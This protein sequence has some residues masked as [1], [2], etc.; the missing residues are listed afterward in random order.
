MA[1]ILLLNGPNLNLLGQ[2]E[3]HLYGDSTL[4]DIE[5]DLSARA[6]KA[7]HSLDSFQSCA[8][9]ELLKRIQNCTN[10]GTAMIPF[11]PAAFTHTSVALRDGLLATGT[12]FLEIHLSN[13]AS[14]EPFRRQSFFS[15][16]AVGLIAGFGAYSY[17]L[18]LDAAIRHLA[19]A[20][21]KQQE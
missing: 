7:G 18:A 19:N 8:E 13:P 4:A 10:D 9:H 15:D 5:K 1:K 20:A 3:P 21:K 14:R 11:N 16:I 6:E 12:P 17:Q 2:R